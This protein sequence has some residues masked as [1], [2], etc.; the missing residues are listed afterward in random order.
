VAAGYNAFPIDLRAHGESGGHYMT[1]GY[2]EA[3]DILGA[4]DA[5]RGRGASGAFVA[6]GH[7]SGAVAA[8]QAGA[9]SSEI[10]AVIAD[11]AFISADR[12]LERAAAIVG[13]DAHASAAEKL[14]LRVANRLLHSSWGRGF[15]NYAFWVRTG[16]RMDAH[17]ADALPAI[18]RL[19]V[20]PVLFIVGQ[21]DG[22]ATPEDAREMYE[23]AASPQKALLVIPG[24]GHNTTY[25][26]A[27]DE[28]AGEVLRF[29]TAALASGAPV[30]HGK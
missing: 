14:A 30:V 29:L 27:P 6:L 26:A 2:L 21:Q 11:G 22:I 1:P 15:A 17:D 19:G 23:A 8:L 18:A 10:A 28:Y 24:A 25:S 13:R 12:V 5:A 7:S 4:V 3:L 20:R 16:V 9:R